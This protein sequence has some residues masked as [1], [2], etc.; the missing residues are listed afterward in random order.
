MK[1]SLS[2]VDCNFCTLHNIPTFQIWFRTVEY[3]FN[4]SSPW[5]SL[6]WHIACWL[7]NTTKKGPCLRRLRICHSVWISRDSRTHRF[8][9][10]A[11]GEFFLRNSFLCCLFTIEAIV[12]EEPWLEPN[13]VEKGSRNVL[14][15]LLVLFFVL[16]WTYL[17]DDWLI[18]QRNGEEEREKH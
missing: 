5:T 16:N 1:K 17:I 7:D 6:Q 15:L 9:F 12:F 2:Y 10:F 4:V 13:T 11:F 14:V 18:S 3:A 8:F